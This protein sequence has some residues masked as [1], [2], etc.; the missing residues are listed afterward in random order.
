MPG[1]INFIEPDVAL[2]TLSYGPHP[3][4]FGQ[5]HRPAT[6]TRLPVMVI[7]HGGYWKDNHN[8][9]SYAT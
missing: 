9:N 6:E 2:K 7:V 4:Q 5:L 1:N 3:E 8:L